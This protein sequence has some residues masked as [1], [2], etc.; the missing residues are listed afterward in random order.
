M[1]LILLATYVSQRKIEMQAKTDETLHNDVFPACDSNWGGVVYFMR[2]HF[3]QRGITLFTFTMLYGSAFGTNL[4]LNGSFEFSNFVVGGV[5]H[6]ATSQ[7]LNS[8]FGASTFS[9]GEGGQGVTNWTAAAG[10]GGNGYYIYFSPSIAKTVSA[11]N[12]WNSTSEMLA[13]SFTG[14]SPDGGNFV[15]IDGDASLNSSI[16]QTI[17][18]LTNGVK[19]TLVFNWAATQLQSKSGAT[20]EAV[21]V[22]FGSVDSYTT[23][24]KNTPTQGFNGWYT[25][26][27]SFTANASSELL[28]FFAIG[29]PTGLPPVVLLDGI[30][31][32]PP[33]S[34]PEPGTITMIGLGAAL[35]VISSRLRRRA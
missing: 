19:Y 27:V 20:T 6:N 24:V 32:S 3:F 35:I 9:G 29:T 28:T 12:Q 34:V 7:A 25:E 10:T 17:G 14:A 5:T 11:T 33:S 16:S 31:L 4:V 30:S 18:G 2:F 1:T 13:A 21:K 23:A 26:T 15:M 22:T 8:Q